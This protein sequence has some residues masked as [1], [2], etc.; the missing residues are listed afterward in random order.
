MPSLLKTLTNETIGQDETI[1]NT[2]I[3]SM[4]IALRQA[5]LSF[6]KKRLKGYLGLGKEREDIGFEKLEDIAVKIKTV[7]FPDLS[8]CYFLYSGPM[9]AI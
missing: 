8:T 1:F 9:E 4:L 5:M 7:T 3:C 2:L 6:L